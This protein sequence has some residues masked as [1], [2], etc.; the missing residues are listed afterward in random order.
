M[1]QRRQQFKSS[2]STGA[3]SPAKIR[4]QG[5]PVGVAITVSRFL[6]VKTLSKLLTSVSVPLSLKWEI[7]VLTT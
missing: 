7:T 4:V 6:A 3:S 1:M 5:H 2:S